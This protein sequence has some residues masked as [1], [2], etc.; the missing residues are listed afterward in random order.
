MTLEVVNATSADA[1]HTCLNGKF[2]DFTYLGGS[3]WNSGSAPSYK[4][5]VDC[6]DADL[7]EYL[8]AF[9]CNAFGQWQLSWNH[10]RNG[11]LI[12]TGSMGYISVTGNGTDDIEVRLGVSPDEAYLRKKV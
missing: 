3:Q 8:M 9:V 6:G 11:T 1:L 7:H 2:I 10:Y 4:V 12:N 5:V